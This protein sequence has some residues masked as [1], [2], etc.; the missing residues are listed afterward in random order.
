MD[1]D[2]H[3]YLHRRSDTNQVFYVGIGSKKRAFYDKRRNILWKR[4]VQK[5]GYTIEILYENITLE[6]ACKIEIELI[7]QYGKLDNGGILANMTD[8]GEGSRGRKASVKTIEKSRKR[9]LDNNPMKDPTNKQRSSEWMKKIIYTEERR[10]NMSIAHKGYK[11]SEES[12]KKRSAK[13]KG[14]SLPGRLII[15]IES[16][17]FYL[18][19]KEA[20]IAY[21]LPKTTLD[22][23]LSGIRKNKTSLRLA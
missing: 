7:K 18:S 10:K 3:V 21:N 16:G 1:T 20:R 5:Y 12:I 23:Y 15:N 6:E 11:Q 8:G 4:I 9:F 17:I 13:A 2:I 19:R 14:K 22:S